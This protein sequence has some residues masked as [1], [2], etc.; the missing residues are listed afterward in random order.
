MDGKAHDA[1]QR[2]TLALL[3]SYPNN[4]NVISFLLSHRAAA[5]AL[6]IGR[7]CVCMYVSMTS[8]VFAT[9]H[10]QVVLHRAAD[11]AS[12]STDLAPFWPS[13]VAPTCVSKA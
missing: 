9:S 10:D 3:A 7:T 4:N 2:G 5:V 6:V 13:R 11:A 12:W 1:C 8:H